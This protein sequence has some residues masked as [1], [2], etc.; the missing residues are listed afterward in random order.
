MGRLSPCRCSTQGRSRQTSAVVKTV[1]PDLADESRGLAAALRSLTSVCPVNQRFLYS[2][3]ISATTLRTGLLHP[4]T[5]D[6]AYFRIHPNGVTA[7]RNG[8][9][10]ATRRSLSDY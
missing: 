10:A 5:A 9:G 6:L 3:L 4:H 1:S 7:Q 2:L 8:V